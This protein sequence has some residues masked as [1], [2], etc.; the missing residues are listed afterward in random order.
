MAEL[1]QLM[2]QLAEMNQANQQ[3]QQTMFQQAMQAVQK[4]V[5]SVETTVRSAPQG[6]RKMGDSLQKCYTRVEKFT[7][8]PVGWK[9]W[10]YQFGVATAQYDQKTQEIMETVEKM[11]IQE[12]TTER[13]MHQLESDDVTWADDTKM[14]LF[15]AL[16]MLTTG[17]ANVIVRSCED[18]NGYTAWKKLYDRFN[19]KTPAGLTAAWRDVIRIK[20]AKDVREAARNIDVWEGKV[21]LL[22]REH[23]EEPTMGLKASL[24]LEMLPEGAQMTILQGMDTKKLDY[25]ALKGKI[26]MMANIQIDNAT[27]KPMD[28]GEMKRDLEEAWDD[29]DFGE[30]YDVDEVGMQTCHRCGGIGHFA[31]ECGTAKGKGKDGAKGKGK[32]MGKGWI[33]KGKGKGQYNDFGI[34]GGGKSK[35]CFNCGGNHLR[36][37]VP[38]RGQ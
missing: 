30:G 34:K 25:E 9:E 4:V 1:Q 28:I 12:I 27:P 23:G 13:I 17:E 26:K 10:H 35:G 20:K 24:L 5:E 32:S 38:E 19:P 16:G 2:R 15:G 36:S 21:T 31:R 18:K 11:E 22:K 6:V 37:R 7:G 14:G 3:A 8:D 29:F 33:D